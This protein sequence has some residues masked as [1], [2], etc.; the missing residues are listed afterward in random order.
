M[1]LEVLRGTSVP[2]NR[3]MIFG[4]ARGAKLGCLGKDRL[5]I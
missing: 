2:T 5:T 4:V 1:L 3:E